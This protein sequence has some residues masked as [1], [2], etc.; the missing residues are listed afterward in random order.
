M[1][2]NLAFLLPRLPQ[3]SEMAVRDVAEAFRTI[4]LHPSQWPAA[5]VRV[6][7][8]E[9]YVDTCAAFGTASSG[10]VHGSLDDAGCDILRAQ[11]IGPIGKWVDDHFFIRLRIEH[12]KTFN[13]IRRTWATAI[14]DAGGARHNGG[15][16]LYEGQ[17]ADGGHFELHEDCSFPLQDLSRSSSRSPHDQLFTYN[18][19]DVDR[20]TSRLG[21]PWESAKDH[22]FASTAPYIGFL[23]DLERCAVSLLEEKREKYLTAIAEWS[24]RSAHNLRHVQEL[25]GKL[26]HS[27]LVIPSGRAYLTKLET[28]LSTSHHN[29]HVLR[30][31]PNGLASDIEWWRQRLSCSNITRLLPK[32]AKH[33]NIAAYSDASSGVGIAIIIVINPQR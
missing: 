12:L 28:M 11:G 30:R 21:F 9:F 3:G 8:D 20:H 24:L 4:P 5:A 14:S 22:A 7:D 18:L 15:R 17:L 27:C 33:S 31:P 10:G 26:L 6:D 2:S 13:A 25:Y 23:W 32:P 19:K 29:P 16:I 1:F